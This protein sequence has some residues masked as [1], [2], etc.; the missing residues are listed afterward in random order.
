MKLRNMKLKVLIDL[1]SYNITLIKLVLT[2]WK[3]PIKKYGSIFRKLMKLLLIQQ[4]VVNMILHYLS[5]IIF[6]QMITLTLPTRI[7]MMSLILF[8][9]EIQCSQRKVP[10]QDLVMVNQ[11][12]K[13]SLSSIS[14]GIIFS[15]GESF[16]NLMSMT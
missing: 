16:H 14:F 6:L 2:I 7:S 10:F 9:K 1:W 13:K 5:M 11:P 3:N 8:L 12:L 4:V 15:L